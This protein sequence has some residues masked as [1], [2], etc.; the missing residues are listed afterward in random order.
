MP[1]S[2][3]RRLMPQPSPNSHHQH[4]SSHLRRLHAV[5]CHHP[6]MRQHQQKC[7]GKNG[8]SKHIKSKYDYTEMSPTL[9]QTASA[10]LSTAAIDLFPLS[11]AN[12]NYPLSKDIRQYFNNGSLEHTTTRNAICPVKAIDKERLTMGEI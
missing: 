11:L 10:T 7:S 6:Q 8:K 3:L 2:I 9:T 12:T 5:N 4:C 1:R